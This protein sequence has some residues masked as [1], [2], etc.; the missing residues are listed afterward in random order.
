MATLRLMLLL[1]ES[2]L[3]QLYRQPQQVIT[4][5]AQLVMM[6]GVGENQ[7]ILLPMKCFMFSKILQELQHHGGNWIQ[8]LPHLRLARQLQLHLQQVRVQLRL[9][10]V[11]VAQVHPA[12]AHPVRVRVHL[13]QVQVHPVHLARHQLALAQVVVRL[14]LAQALARQQRCP[15]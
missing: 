12:Q 13:A 1:G 4:G 6:N 15:N 14:A 2:Q 7:S 9:A 5:L 10:L 3:F 8:L 11:L